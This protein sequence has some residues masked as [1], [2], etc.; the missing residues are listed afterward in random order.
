MYFCPAKFEV[1]TIYHCKVRVKNIS[2]YQSLFDCYSRKT[3]KNLRTG[4]ISSCFMHISMAA[5]VSVLPVAICRGEMQNTGPYTVKFCLRFSHETN[6][7][8]A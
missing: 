5:M 6:Q 1:H 2:S 8:V 3:A 7:R 4:L